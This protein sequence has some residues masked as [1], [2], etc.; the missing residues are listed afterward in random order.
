MISVRH[1]FNYFANLIFLECLSSARYY[2]KIHLGV[3]FGIEDWT[4]YPCDIQ[5]NSEDKHQSNNYTNKCTNR[6]FNDMFRLI[7]LICENFIFL[8]N[9]AS[10]IYFSK[11]THSLH[12]QRAK[13]REKKREKRKPNLRFFSLH[14]QKP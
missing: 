8:K 5:R 9:S 6:C 11:L 7:K 2:V 4:F 3:I 12:I 14:F 1:A 10:V 13:D